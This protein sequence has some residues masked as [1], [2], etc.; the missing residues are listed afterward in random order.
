MEEK[1]SAQFARQKHEEQGRVMKDN[2][3]DWELE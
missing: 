1:G 3:K 2:R